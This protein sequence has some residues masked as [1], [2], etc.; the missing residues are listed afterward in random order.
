MPLAAASATLGP[1]LAVAAGSTDPVGIAAWTL[2]GATICGTLPGCITSFDPTKNTVMLVTAGVVL[3]NSGGFV[4]NPVS[5]A[6]FGLSL[7]ASSGSA[8]AVGVAK[9]VNIGT[10][11]VDWM[12]AYGSYGVAGLVGF[13]GP[14]PPT[15]GAVTGLGSVAFTNEDIGPSLA[16]AAG[17]TDEAGILKWTAIGGVILT[18]IK[19]NGAIAPGSMQNPAVGGPVVGAGSFS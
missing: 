6:A 3:P 9:W 1:A 18:A 19:T 5:A 17:S 11:I 12:G 16:A 15:N 7:A 4:T 14:A 8:D 10:A 2:I 13:P